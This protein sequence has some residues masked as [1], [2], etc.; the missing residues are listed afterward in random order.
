[1]DL[2][3]KEKKIELCAK[4]MTLLRNA[5]KDIEVRLARAVS[6]AQHGFQMALKNQLE[7]TK[8]TYDMFLQY[9]RRTDEKFQKQVAELYEATE[10]HYS[11]YLAELPLIAEG[12]ARELAPTD[13]ESEPDT[14]DED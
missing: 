3:D 13:S 10:I 12:L 4:Q 2:H 5:T 8:Y 7:S 9:I 14:E 6:D 11:Q 1:M